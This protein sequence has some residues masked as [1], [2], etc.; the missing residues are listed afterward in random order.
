MAVEVDWGEIREKIAPA[1]IATKSMTEGET[2]VWLLAMTASIK[3]SPPDTP[4]SAFHPSSS[5]PLLKAGNCRAGLSCMALSC[6]GFLRAGD[7]LKHRTMTDFGKLEGLSTP[8]YIISTT[9][10]CLHEAGKA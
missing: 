4:K 3:R 1:K 8:Q 6:C 2:E 10:I 5:F 7:R 9:S